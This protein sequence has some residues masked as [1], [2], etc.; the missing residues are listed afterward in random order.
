LSELPI[1]VRLDH[2]SLVR[3]D[4]LPDLIGP[5]TL[6]RLVSEMV[7]SLFL[8]PVGYEMMTGI[9]HNAFSPSRPR[10]FGTDEL[11]YHK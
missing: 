3:V 1:A 4:A 10:G 8:L 9:A 7:P 5:G 11:L 2:R 6:Q